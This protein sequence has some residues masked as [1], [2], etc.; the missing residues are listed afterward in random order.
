M[1][2]AK[3]TIECKTATLVAV[4]LIQYHLETTLI[5]H[6]LGVIQGIKTAEMSVQQQ[7]MDTITWRIIKNSKLLAI[8]S[9]QIYYESIITL[10]Y[11]VD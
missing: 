11:K 7:Q 9:S 3:I 5:N 8:K 6:E 2:H 1:D 4:R 10:N